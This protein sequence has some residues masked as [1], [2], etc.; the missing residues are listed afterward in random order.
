MNQSS[1]DSPSME[2]ITKAVKKATAEGL[3]SSTA[4][5]NLQIWL[6]EDRLRPVS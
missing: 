1:P 3:I 5:E 2:A 4:E 6:R